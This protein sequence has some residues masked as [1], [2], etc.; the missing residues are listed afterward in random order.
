MESKVVTYIAML[1]AINVSGQK[2]IHMGELLDMFKKMNYENVQTYIQS[3]N[4]VFENKKTNPE[5]LSHSISKKI[6]D[7]FGFDVEVIVKTKEEV[8]TVFNNNPFIKYDLDK[9]YVTFLSSAPSQD[10]NL[11]HFEKEVYQI[12]GDIIYLH[13]GERI[14]DSKLNNNLI[15]KKLQVI[16]T[17]R[18]WKTITQLFEIANT[19]K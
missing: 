10:K 6:K 12:I 5:I 13:Y 3:G 15:E 4:V 17:T 8:E 19:T 9:M 18:N 11:G 7:V 14:S 1:R 2:I 16:A